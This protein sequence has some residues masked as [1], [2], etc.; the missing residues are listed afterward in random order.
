M[1]AVAN[2]TASV[3]RLYPLNEVP[4]TPTKPYGSYSAT[5]GRGD[6]YTLSAEGIR[7]G[8]VVV[9]TFG[10]TATSALS[11]AEAA[12]TALVGTRLAI[13]GYETTPC[14]AELDPVVNRDPDDSGLVGVT[15]TYTFTATKETT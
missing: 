5:L 9:Q 11:K 2:A 10:N 8:R 6:V 15:A 3:A 1:E 12:R 14:R 13:T 7:W 4:S